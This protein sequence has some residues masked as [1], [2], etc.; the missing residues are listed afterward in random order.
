MTRTTPDPASPSPNFCITPGEE[1]YLRRSEIARFAAASDA[2]RVEL[3]PDGAI[4]AAV[5]PLSYENK[6]FRCIA[7]EDYLRGSRR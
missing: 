7:H 6:S 3:I 1:V 5:N 2:I 4:R